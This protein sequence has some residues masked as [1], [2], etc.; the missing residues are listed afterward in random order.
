MEGRAR[1]TLRGWGW[2]M[3]DGG[4][5]PGGLPRHLPLSSTPPLPPP[6]LPVPP[7]PLF[8][9]D[10]KLIPRCI[11]HVGSAALLFGERGVGDRAEISDASGEGRRRGRCG[12]RIRDEGSTSG[13]TEGFRQSTL[14]G[15]HLHGVHPRSLLTLAGRGAPS[16]RR[17]LGLCA[18]RPTQPPVDQHEARRHVTMG[19]WR[20]QAVQ[21]HSL[22]R[23]QAVLQGTTA[24]RGGNTRRHRAVLRFAA[25]RLRTVLRGDTHTHYHEATPGR[26]SWHSEWGRRGWGREI[27]W[28]ETQSLGKEWHGRRESV[29]QHLGRGGGDGATQCRPPWWHSQWRRGDRPI[30][31][32]HWRN[33]GKHTW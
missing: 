12:G 32:T 10:A 13:S 1:G 6:L 27:V 30:S 4:E 17:I 19:L 9:G 26:P 25:A 18:D 2:G 31:H 15:S 5:W 29:P 22:G 24:H 33:L 3:G 16:R 20:H 28:G 7:P 11:S 23:S 8:G 14:R 21:Q